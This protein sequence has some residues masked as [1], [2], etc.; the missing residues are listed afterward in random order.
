MPL[1]PQQLEQF[2]NNPANYKDAPDGYYSLGGTSGLDGYKNLFK[3]EGSSL[4]PTF[5]EIDASQVSA[6]PITAQQWNQIGNIRPL[7]YAIKPTQTKQASDAA[8]NAAL[9]DSTT[10]RVEFD[11]QGGQAVQGSGQE[12]NGNQALMEQQQ[13]R[14][15]FDKQETP[16]VPAGAPMQPAQPVQQLV[17][18]Q[19]QQPVSSYT[20]SSIVDY[21]K[22]IGQGSDFASRSALAKTLG[23]ANYSGT[24]A[25]NTQMLNTLR[26]RGATGSNTSVPDSVAAGVRSNQTGTGISSNTSSTGTSTTGS[27]TTASQPDVI[28]G[29]PTMDALLDQLKDASPQTAF[30]Q[31][32][33]QIYDDLGLQTIKSQY[34]AFS[35]EYSDLKNKKNE[36]ALDINNNPWYT[37]SK[38]IAELKRLDDRYE[39]KE[40]N[41]TE[42]IKLLES[43]YDNGRQDAQFVAG[44]TMDQANRT[45]ELNKDIIM[46]AIDLAEKE[47]ESSSKLSGPTAVQEYQFAKSEG[48]TGS[49]TQ[50]QNEDANRKAKANSPSLPTVKEQK[51]AIQSFLNT[52]VTPNGQKVGNGKGSDGYVDPYVYLEAF[53]QWGGTNAE[54]LTAF[55]PEKNVNPESLN[56]LPEAIR[57][58]RDL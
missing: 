17:Q 11:S 10:K 9:N 35:K 15:Q 27:S 21:L 43:M 40:S 16:I 33:K 8:Y 28:T 13:A 54:F 3:K 51:S 39:G 23:V 34:E 38:R 25:Q 53:R 57:P 22:S 49:F 50:Y 52:G 48:Y 19:T 24:A 5:E 45:T 18:Q 42:R 31:V 37:E 30:S 14:E 20:G 2:G 6:I 26:T 44:K 32:Y 55:P 41:L 1:T 29:N 4:I 46:K 12:I 36:E 7:E 47:S 58:K 56:L